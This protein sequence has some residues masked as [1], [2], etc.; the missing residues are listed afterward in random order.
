MSQPSEKI[1]WIPT[2]D[3]TKIFSPSVSK[4]GTG[5]TAEEEPPFEI[6]NWCWNLLS[7]WLH[8]L[9]G[10]NAYNVVISSDANE[11]DYA[12]LEAYIAAGAVAGDRVL[13]K[14]DQAVTAQ[15]TIPDNIELTLQKGKKFTCAANLAQVLEIGTGLKIK[16]D[17]VVEMSHT[18][19]AVSIITY[20]G[21]KSHADN[22]IVKNTSTGTITNCFIINAAKTGN[23]SRGQTENTGGGT[24]TNVLVDNSSLT[25]NDMIIREV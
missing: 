7:K 14:N 15:I 10:C 9:Q 24:I 12:S 3:G 2:D 21:D 18:G 16:G 19:T 20:N 11:Y 25:T 6:F 4:R 17:F 22:I 23:F 8:W 1:N 13:L 5:W